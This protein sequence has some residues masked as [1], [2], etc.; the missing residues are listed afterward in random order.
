MRKALFTA[1][2][3][4]GVI[5]SMAIAVQAAD[6]TIP[7]ANTPPVIDGKD[8]S[9]E[10]WANAYHVFL[11]YETGDW[12]GC[13]VGDE[14]KFGYIQDKDNAC[15]GYDVYYMYYNDS[16][17][18][19]NLDY[20]VKNGGIYI[21][22]VA[23]DKSRGKALSEADGAYNAGDVV[24]VA[25]SPLNS[26][27][28]PSNNVSSYLYDFP[29][30]TA[31]NTK[32][33][34]SCYFEHFQY[35]TGE[36]TLG[37]SLG[38]KT[39]S[40]VTADGYFMEIQIPWKAMNVGNRL[41]KHTPGSMMGLG[42]VLMDWVASSPFYEVA[43]FGSG[44]DFLSALQNA[45]KYNTVTFGEITA[46]PGANKSDLSAL[47]SAITTAEGLKESEYTPATWA[48]LAHAVANAKEIT[49]ADPQTKADEAKAQVE[50]AIAALL[51]IADATPFQILQAT[52]ASVSNY[53]EADYDS[54]LWAIMQQALTNA[55]AITEQNTEAEINA[56]NDALTAAI[57]KMLNPSDAD[58]STLNTVINSAKLLKERSFSAEDWAALQAAIVEAEKLTAKNSQYEIDKAV[59]KLN[60][61]MA[62]SNQNTSDKDDSS[63][64]SSSKTE[65]NAFPWWGI[66]I[67]V[68]GVLV[69]AAVVLFIIIKNKKAQNIP[70]EAQPESIQSVESEEHEGS[71]SEENM[72]L[73]VS[74]EQPSEEDK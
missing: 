12:Y 44:T 60:T 13:V 28:R 22:V 4:I 73:E 63:V 57:N 58:V 43:D 47:K 56:A 3:T 23:K 37:S 74:Q 15:E 65:N 48:V 72:N 53:V 36:L 59:E 17:E 8:S 52:I 67:I 18:D 27:S 69:V 62:K 6:F 10:E 51:K 40:T 9:S 39:Q 26:K 24:Q 11:N 54:E 30:Y 19:T 68:V 1:L 46:A 38:I 49:E 42:V 41:P 61:L 21:K 20:E 34:D 70:T 64:N 31:M 25:I 2:I 33:S 45:R 50:K 66:V 7:H 5:F 35:K 29:Y 55:K 71:M 16:S 32:N 14:A